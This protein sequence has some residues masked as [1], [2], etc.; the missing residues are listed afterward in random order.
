MT[1]DPIIRGDR[2]RQI[3]EDDLFIDAFA[4]V[5]R[6][7][8]EDMLTVPW[9]RVRR[10]ADHAARIRAIRDARAAIQS[11]MLNGSD[12]AKRGERGSFFA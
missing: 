11:V 9:W 4:E 7:A 6:R 8:I 10:L 1:D 3:L 12:T 2:A 5:E